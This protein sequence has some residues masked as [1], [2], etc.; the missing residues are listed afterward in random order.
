MPRGARRRRQKGGFIGR[1]VDSAGRL[2]LRHGPKVARAIDGYLRRK[3]K[4]KRSQKNKRKLFKFPKKH[5]GDNISYSKYRYYHKTNRFT[6]RLLAR[7][8]SK[9]EIENF[10]YQLIANTTA[11]QAIKSFNILDGNQLYRILDDYIGITVPPNATDNFTSRCYLTKVKDKYMI[12]N[13]TSA[14][15]KVQIYDIVP[16]HDI[17]ATTD[18]SHDLVNYISTGFVDE[19]GTSVYVWNTSVFK[20][21]RFTTAFK[22]MKVHSLHLTPGATHQH[23]V[24]CKS[25]TKLNPYRILNL[26][27][28]SATM[29][30][31][32]FITGLTRFILIVVNG[33]PVYVTNTSSVSTATIE[34][35]IARETE[36]TLK[37][38]KENETN[39]VQR[40]V[41]THT[42][43]ANTR[44]MADDD[45]VAIAQTAV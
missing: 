23:I 15:Q 40:D 26:G 33:T 34:C 9:N 16:R 38:L 36:F 35:L 19:G 32:C 21:R 37:I 18:A 10:S 41:L 20:S 22:V 6:D 8:G 14:T 13:A 1:T 27:Q 42:G 11:S 45:F 17:M 25:A 4:N 44:M 3:G 12:S 31:P 7:L 24:S 39:I 43:I 29:T 5:I 2:V 28:S 30:G